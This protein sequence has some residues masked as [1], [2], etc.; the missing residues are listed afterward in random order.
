MSRRLL[1]AA[2]LLASLTACGFQRRGPRAMPFKRIYLQMNPYS[3]MAANIRRQLRAN[4]DTQVTERAEEAD[5]VLQ[6]LVD[7]KEKTIVSLNAG[8]TVREFQLR[9]RLAFRLTGK[10]GREITP[11]NEIFVSRDLLNN[12]G[13]VLARDA[14]E[15]I[16]YRDMENDIVQQLIRRLSATKMDRVTEPVDK[17]K[18]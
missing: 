4:G 3:E 15:S 7:A 11:Y 8:G 12:D 16:L 9:Q 17:T 6:V 2:L 1:L 13:Q 14:E 10:D 18:P 5:V